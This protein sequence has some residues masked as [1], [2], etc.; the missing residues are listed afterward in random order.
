MTTF[1]SSDRSTDR[2][3]KQK[4]V[5]LLLSSSTYWYHP[6]WNTC[7]ISYANIKMII[8]NDWQRIF[9]Y[10]PLNILITHTHVWYA[11]IWMFWNS[12]KTHRR[13]RKNTNKEMKKKKKRK[14][15]HVWSQLKKKKLV[16][17]WQSYAC[18][19]SQSDQ[20]NPKWNFTRGDIMV[21]GV[22]AHAVNILCIFTQF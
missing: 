13:K 8:I 9:K 12:F 10:F 19:K 20:D 6:K 18:I 15:S 17:V 11:H 14:Y 7:T 2:S 5:S 21:L 3:T 16:N 1:P 4:W 22:E